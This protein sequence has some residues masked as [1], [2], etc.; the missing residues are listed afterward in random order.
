[1]IKCC[2]RY[3]LDN[4][5]FIPGG[6][7]MA[8]GMFDGLHQG[9][10]DIIKS[11]VRLAENTGLLACVQTFRNFGK[12]GEER[13]LY[14]MDERIRM[15]EA[16]GV[17]EMLVLNFPQVKDMSPEEYC[18]EILKTRSGAAALFIG[19]DYR[20]GKGASGDA[21]MLKEFASREKIS[22]RVISDRMLEDTD[23][24]ISTTWLRE[25][26]SE[27]DVELASRLCGGRPYSYSGRV[28]HGKQAGRSMGFPTANLEIPEDKFVVRRGV[29]CAR[30]TLGN[31]TLY[32]VT[33]VGRR[34][35]VED[36]VNDVAETFIF[37]FDEDI[38]GATIKV[39]LMKFLRPEQPFSGVE[40]LTRAVEE[41]KAQ[42]RS[43]F[44]I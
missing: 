44:G 43:F 33:N 37:D 10:V 6:R 25:A 19:H 42:A 5:P 14:T 4:L 29:Y 26:L 21:A 23:R 9:H 13:L 35:T 18:E 17:D 28:C 3:S 34:P 22:L 39:E 15:L 11:A 2:S 27:G 20:F 32:G 7:V 8:L 41:N 36:A 30:V 38:Y 16:L 24:R 1:M 40:E 12:N 31:R